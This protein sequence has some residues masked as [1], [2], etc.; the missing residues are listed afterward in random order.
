MTD[1]MVACISAGSAIVVGMLSLIGVVT[2]NAKANSKIEKQLEI[3][4]AVTDTKIEALTNEVHEH[5]N[6]ARRMPIVE[7]K[8]EMMSKTI[9]ELRGYHKGE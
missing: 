7:T 9:E 1:V 4:Q 3:A 5:N 6:F 8:I 2:T